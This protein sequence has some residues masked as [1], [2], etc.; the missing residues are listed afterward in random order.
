MAFEERELK[1]D[2]RELSPPWFG[3]SRFPLNA[4]D[5]VRV[6]KLIA[7]T[8]EYSREEVEVKLW[9]E[10]EP[11]SRTL[12]MT[13]GDYDRFIRAVGTIRPPK[14]KKS[15]QKR[16]AVIQRSNR[17]VSERGD[18]GMAEQPSGQRERLVDRPYEP[19]SDLESE[20]AMYEEVRT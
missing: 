1:E 16:T 7:F 14:S 3:R 13:F 20:P 18:K 11:D 4:D 5:V 15:L 10:G 9:L 19:T 17:Q 6:D 12:L 8:A 2:V